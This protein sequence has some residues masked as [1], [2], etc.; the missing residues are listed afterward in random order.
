M[1]ILK[2]GPDRYIHIDR[3][4]Y[5]EP[6]SKGQLIVHFAIGGGIFAAATLRVRLEADEAL[7]LRKWLDADSAPHS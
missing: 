2:V 4:T 1:T 7:V 5:T 3:M 6:G